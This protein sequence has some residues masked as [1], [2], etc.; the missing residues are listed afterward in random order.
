MCPGSNCVSGLTK[1]TGKIVRTERVKMSKDA[2]EKYF[3]PYIFAN[4]NQVHI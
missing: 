1:Y 3:L 2:L 4:N